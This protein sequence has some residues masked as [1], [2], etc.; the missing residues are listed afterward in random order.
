MNYIIG[1]AAP[2][3]FNAQA[4]VVRIDI[5]AEEIATSPRPL[6]AGIVADAK[7]ALAQLTSA[8]RDRLTTDVFRVW[9]DRLTRTEPVQT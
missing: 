5:D 8:V 9:R 4:K 2:P 6:D 7:I 1:H 3:R